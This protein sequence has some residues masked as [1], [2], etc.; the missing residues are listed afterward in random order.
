MGSA[1]NRLELQEKIQ[2]K[3]EKHPGLLLNFS[4]PIAMRV[5][6]LLSGVT[7]P[8]AARGHCHFEQPTA[9]PRVLNFQL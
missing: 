3:L 7:T 6:E 8:F 5:D 4:Q 9:F 1:S 2:K